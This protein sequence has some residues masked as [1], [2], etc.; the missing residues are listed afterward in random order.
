VSVLLRLASLLLA[1]RIRESDSHGTRQVVSQLIGATPLRLIHF[2]VGLFRMN[3]PDD[4]SH[5]QP[6]TLQL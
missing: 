4:D 6:P 3:T 2:P 5:N 1:V